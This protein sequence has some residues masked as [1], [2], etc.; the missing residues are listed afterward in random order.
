MVAGFRPPPSGFSRGL[1]N[2][3][4]AKQTTGATTFRAYCSLS[5]SDAFP[6]IAIHAR[7]SAWWRPSCDS[8]PYNAIRAVTEYRSS[9][10]FR[11]SHSSMTYTDH[12]QLMEQCIA[13]CQACLVAC[14]GCIDSCL[15]SEHVATLTECIRL[16]RDCSDT[17]TQCVRFMARGSHFHGNMCAVCAE[18]CM[19]CAGECEKHHEVAACQT[20]AVACRRCEE[21]CRQMGQM[22]I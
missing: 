14:E 16:C 19:A 11:M 5:G 18:V 15:T 7:A 6:L 2:S 9:G 22:A 10:G 8:Q 3:Q 1:R 13:N 20:C 21:T 12:M 4:D 17:C